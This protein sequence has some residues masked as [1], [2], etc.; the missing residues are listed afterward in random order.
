MAVVTE[1]DTRLRK[2]VQTAPQQV[3]SLI[4]E[5]ILEG[6]L[7]PGAR[8]PS[9][10]EMAANFG[11]SRPTVREA[12]RSLKSSGVVVA[13]RGSRGGH[14]VSE[15]STAGLARGMGDYMTLAIG[16]QHL[17]YREILEVRS[18]L[19]PLAVSDAAQRR[20]QDDI[21]S[22]KCLSIMHPIGD[23]ATW[24]VRDALR[25]DL[26]FHRK[27]AECSHNQLIVAFVS[28]TII[29][30]QDCEVDFH[31]FSPTDLVAHLDEVRDAVVLGDSAGACE[32]MRRH[33][34]LS[35]A[36]RG[37]AIGTSN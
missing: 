20:T 24:T 14:R 30:F 32:A 12:L 13:A 10:A 27:L 34:G 26:A 23:P 9:E 8:L 7:L 4:K 16:A 29:A 33:M 19:E 35:G 17:S 22:L 2:K 37:L 28:A 1:C 31:I 3:A 11:V 21:E 25:Y 18:K 5:A 15:F 36:T 6:S